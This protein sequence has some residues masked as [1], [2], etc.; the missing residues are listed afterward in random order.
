[1]S[2][3]SGSTSAWGSSSSDIGSGGRYWM[4]RMVLDDCLVLGRSLNKIKHNQYFIN[5]EIVT[6][7]NMKHTRTYTHFRKSFV[8]LRRDRRGHNRMIFGFTTSSQC[9][10]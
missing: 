10:K 8:K 9:L 6:T 2:L 5:D 1:M 7:T 3:S 4:S